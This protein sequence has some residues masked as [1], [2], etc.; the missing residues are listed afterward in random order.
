MA[1]QQR[2]HNEFDECRQC[3]HGATRT[4]LIRIQ[5]RLQHSERVRHISD[6]ILKHGTQPCRQGTLTT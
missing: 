6:Q 1:H 4:S 3:Q 2:P 5:V